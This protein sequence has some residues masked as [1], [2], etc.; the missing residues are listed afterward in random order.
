MWKN[1]MPELKRLL[2][3][4]VLKLKLK[5]PVEKEGENSE[6]L[7]ANKK[8][9]FLTAGYSHQSWFSEAHKHTHKQHTA[10]CAQMQWGAVTGVV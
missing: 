4:Y 3:F 6:D 1:E 9:D 10:Y 2:L 7:L 5:W 8:R